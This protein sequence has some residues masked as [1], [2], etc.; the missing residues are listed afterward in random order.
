MKTLWWRL[1]AAVGLLMLG[2]LGWWGFRERAWLTYL[3]RELRIEGKHVVFTRPATEITFESGGLT[4]R[5]S[6]YLPRGKGPF[7]GIVLTHGGTTQG[8]KLPLYPVLSRKLAQRGYVVLSFDFRGYGESDEPTHFETAADFDFVEDVKQAVSFLLTVDRVDSAQIYLAGHSFGAGVIVPAGVQD[9]RIRGIISIAPGRR[10]YELMF[11]PD[12]PSRHYPRHRLAADM[13]I[14]E[15]R[16]LSPNFINPMLYAVTIDT[17]LTFPQHPP[18]LLIDGAL[19]SPED[20]AFLRDLAARVT[21]PITYLSIANAEHYFGVKQ[22]EPL[23][24][25]YHL[26]TYWPDTMNALIEAIDHWIGG[27]K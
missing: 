18:V 3:D 8:R 12:A 19:E 4:L 17:L 16:K 25:R 6:L 27:N 10:G 2:L 21:P 11:G 20:L 5:G 15:L 14:P 13:E 9:E 7:P 1:L 23:E 24:G 22:D 26:V